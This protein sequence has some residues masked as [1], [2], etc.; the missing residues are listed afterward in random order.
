M[1]NF[2]A[3]YNY[4]TIGLEHNAHNQYLQVWMESGIF[5]LIAFLLCLGMGLFK[6][7]ENPGYVCFILIFSL[8]CLTESIGER[9][10]GVVFFTLFQVLFLGIVKKKE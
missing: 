7:W 10:K 2:Y 9:Q 3:H 4:S 5:G 6:L 8:M 1:D